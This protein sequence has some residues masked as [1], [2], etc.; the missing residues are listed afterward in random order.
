MSERP[1]VLVIVRRGQDERFSALEQ[2]LAREPVHI[3]WDRRDAERR[4]QRLAVAIER[5]QRQRRR[6]PPV[7]WET[8]DFAVVDAA[9]PS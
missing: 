6:P 2:L 4:R 9:P 3:T 7:S 5:R 1:R 8:L